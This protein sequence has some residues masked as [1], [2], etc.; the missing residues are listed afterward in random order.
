MLKAISVPLGVGIGNRQS[1]ITAYTAAGSHPSRIYLYLP[2]FA[3]EVRAALAAGKA[4]GFT[5]YRKLRRKP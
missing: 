4:V 2:E 5:D 1:D 3:G